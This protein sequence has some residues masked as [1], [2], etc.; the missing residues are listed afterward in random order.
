MKLL[1]SILVLAIATTAS[2]CSDDEVEFDSGCMSFDDAYA[3][4]YDFLYENLPSYD[5]TNAASLGF[6]SSSIP[7]TDGLEDGIAT[8]ALNVSL[9]ALQSYEWAKGVE[10][11]I[12]NEYVA[13]YA[14]VNEARTNIRPLLSSA[15]SAIID[16]ADEAPTDVSSVVSLINSNMWKSETNNL[17]QTVVFKSSQTPLIYDP[18]STLVY[19]FASCTGV[20]ILFVDALRSVGVPARIAGT[21]AWN[22][23]YE[24]GNHNWI[25]VYDGGEWNFIEAAPAGGGESLSNPCDKWFCSPAKMANG[26]KFYAARWDKSQGT[27]YPM[28][29]DLD[30]AEVPGDDRTEYY[31]SACGQC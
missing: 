9:E 8:L 2:S 10:Q 24:N 29:W 1:S 16:A 17:S 26:T 23:V 31:Q 27:V 12:F 30:N 21:P 5:V 6:H 13:A 11:E 7:D 22:D 18:M 4:A 25:E 19:G 20:S 15:M 14:N 3:S 28:A